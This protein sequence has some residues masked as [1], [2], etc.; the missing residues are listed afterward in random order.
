MFQ[1]KIGQFSNKPLPFNCW[2]LQKRFS[3]F[4]AS[5]CCKYSFIQQL[6]YIFYSLLNFFHSFMCKFM[7]FYS[8]FFYCVEKKLK[9]KAF[10]Y[11]IVS[12]KLIKK[13]Q[14]LPLQPSN[15]ALL[16][17]HLACSA[18]MFISAQVICVLVLCV[19]HYR[20]KWENI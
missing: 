8:I 18:H 15:A 2:L 14:L 1:P 17:I 3:N 9:A 12:G 16:D 6:I 4:H 7:L 10:V 19:A 20:L 11:F 5:F 13:L